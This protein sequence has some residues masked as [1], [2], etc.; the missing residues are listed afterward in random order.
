MTDCILHHW[1]CSQVSA[2]PPAADIARPNDLI[3]VDAA[4]YGTT[5]AGLLRG[6]APPEVQKL[7]GSNGARVK[8]RARATQGWHAAGIEIG[9]RW[10]SEAADAAQ[11]ARIA[12][13]EDAELGKLHDTNGWLAALWHAMEGRN[14]PLPS[15]VPEMFVRLFGN[16][17][18]RVSQLRGFVDGVRDVHTL[19][20]G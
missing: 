9:R 6:E 11:L 3:A 5:P 8:A 18:I 13:I 16:E 4:F 15:A 14:C 17:Y 7:P 10:A 1:T 2:T 19:R 12:D 20:R